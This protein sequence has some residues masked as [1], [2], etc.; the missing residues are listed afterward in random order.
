MKKRK[1]SKSANGRI[2]TGVG[3]YPERVAL[4]DDLSYEELCELEIGP[5]CAYKHECYFGRSG[6]CDPDF[7]QYSNF[8]DW[9][10][11]IKINKTCQSILVDKIKSWGFLF[12]PSFFIASIDF[13]TL[14][15][16]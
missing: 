10:N 9:Q 12:Y 13:E 15:V 7:C 14:S 6:K 11:E 1:K 3:N 8:R 4:S 2:Y 16:F 5:H